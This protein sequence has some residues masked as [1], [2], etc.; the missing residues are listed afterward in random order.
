LT[1]LSQKMAATVKLDPVPMYAYRDSTATMWQHHL[2]I[3]GQR[4]TKKGLIG[5]IKKYVV[6]S[7]NIK[8][9]PRG[10][11]VAIY[12]WHRMDGILIQP[13]YVGHV[14]TYVDYSH[15]I[16]LVW[17]RMKVDGK[18]IDYKESWMMIY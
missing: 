16:R 18:W 7:A 14:N 10:N 11:R 17:R 12:G 13:L 2:I 9:D 1:E 6:L 3:E 5:G 4:K 8:R 15:G